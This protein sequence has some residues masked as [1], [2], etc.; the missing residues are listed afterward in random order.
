M[1][2]ACYLSGHVIFGE[3][4]PDREII[5]ISGRDSELLLMKCSEMKRS[6]ILGKLEGVRKRTNYVQINI[7]IAE[8]SLFTFLLLSLYFNA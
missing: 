2:T 1:G 5:L 7:Q 6:A 3:T 4:N 8:F